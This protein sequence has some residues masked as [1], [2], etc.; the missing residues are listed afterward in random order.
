MNNPLDGFN[1]YT[2]RETW[3]VCL[4]LNNDESTQRYFREMC[5][6]L[7][8]FEAADWIR[9]NLSETFDSVDLGGLMADLLGTAVARVDWPEVADSL[10]N[11]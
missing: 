1:G 11:D 6:G 5:A 9:D 7:S 8:R 3:V 10:L 4:W 2:N